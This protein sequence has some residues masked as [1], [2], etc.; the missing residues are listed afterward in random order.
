MPSM[1]RW[2]SRA[3]RRLRFGQFL[4][5]SAEWLAGFLFAFGAAVLAVKLLIPSAWPHVLWSS[6]ACVPAALVAWMLARRNPYTRTESVAILDR[7]LQT[8]GLLMTLSEQPDQAWH[9]RL[10]QVE[11][12]WRQSL[13]RLVPVRFA[14]TLVLPL[15]FAVAACF[16][17]LRP[18]SGEPIVPNLVGKTASDQLEEALDAL[19]EAKVLEPEEQQQLREEIEKLAEES[20]QQPLTHEKWETVDA[21]RERLKL[22]IDTADIAASK[23]RDAISSLKEALKNAGLTLTQD[24]QQQLENEVM[25]TLRKLQKH[26]AMSSKEGGQKLSSDLQRLMKNGRLS[27]NA[28]ERKK[29]LESLDDFLK[30]ESDK[31]SECRGKCQGGQC[32]GNGQCQGNGSRSGPD[33]DGRP[34][35]GGINRGRG[36]AEL[37][38][39]DESTEDGTKFK[40]IALPPGFL[41]QPGNEVLEIRPTAPD[42]TPAADAPR[43]AARGTDPASG[44]ETTTLRVRP[45][46][47][48]VVKQYFDRE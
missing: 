1:D 37:T 33:G 20:R 12:A 35:R 17:P 4:Q 13:P 29:E 44:R 36:D 10:P 48:A 23:A 5:T 27:E 3:L 7:S 11:A 31:L 22:R 39:G 26:G 34:G 21:L 25:E 24:Q 40:E 47:K 41:D 45:R 8:G 30:K 46:H 2:I 28:D 9:E 15:A 19:E 14:R 32:E 6:A 18:S 16:V 38:Y 42:E 43:S